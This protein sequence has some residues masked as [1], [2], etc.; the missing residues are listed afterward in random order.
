MKHCVV[1]S[2]YIGRGWGLA[3]EINRGTTI[4]EASGGAAREVDPIRKEVSLGEG[5]EAVVVAAV[6]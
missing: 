3:N 4:G 6:R 5:G 1:R 2:L